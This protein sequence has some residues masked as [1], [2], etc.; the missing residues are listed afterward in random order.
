[1]LVNQ[2]PNRP[3]LIT[4]TNNTIY[5]RSYPF[6]STWIFTDPDADL[7]A[8]YQLQVDNNTD[9]LSTYYDSGKTV[10]INLWQ[11]YTGPTVYDLYYWRVTAWDPADDSNTSI[12]G[13]FY[14]GPFIQIQARNSTSPLQGVNFTLTQNAITVYNALTN[15]TGHASGAVIDGLNTTLTIEQTG[16][17]SVNMSFIASHD[18]Y[19]VFTLSPIGEGGGRNT[20]G[21]FTIIAIIIGVSAYSKRK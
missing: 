8:A 18:D 21:F 2:A 3:T 11:N 20:W 16:Y 1:M 19:M 14:V 17:G 6:N 9:F 4:P 7:Q 12:L 10:S 13:R 15:S 5:K